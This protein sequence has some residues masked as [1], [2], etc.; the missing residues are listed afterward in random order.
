VPF[1]PLGCVAVAPAA[2]P[3]TTVLAVVP[4][5]LAV[6]PTLVTVNAIAVAPLPVASPDTVMVW[7]LCNAFAIRLLCAPVTVPA[8]VALPA[9]NALLTVPLTIVLLAHCAML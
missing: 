6:A 7:L 3:L 5:I 1:T 8:V 9:V 4:P 2:A